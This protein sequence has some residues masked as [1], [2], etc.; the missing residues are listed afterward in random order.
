MENGVNGGNGGDPVKGIFGAPQDFA[1]MVNGQ[2][3]SKL[4]DDTKKMMGQMAVGYVD[5]TGD[6]ISKEDYK[7]LEDG[8]AKFKKKGKDGKEEVDFHAMDDW[9]QKDLMVE[10]LDQAYNRK[11]GGKIA[12]ATQKVM[13]FDALMGEK[14]STNG[15]RD[16]DGGQSAE[17]ELIAELEQN[18]GGEQAA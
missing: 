10:S 17:R 13:D 15:Y 8:L 16:T 6:E 2:E 11:F 9:R 5:L 14:Q 12:E 7:E 3:K 1:E 4:P 18:M